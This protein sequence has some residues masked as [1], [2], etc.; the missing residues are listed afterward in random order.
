LPE[1]KGTGAT[2]VIDRSG[3]HKIRIRPC[4]CQEALPLDVQLLRMGLFPTSFIN[5]K[6]VVTFQALED[7]RLDNLE[8]KTALLRY[9]NKLWRKTSINAWPMLPVRSMCL[10]S[11][12]CNEYKNFNV[13]QCSPEPLPRVL[14]SH[15]NVAEYTEYH[16]LWVC[17]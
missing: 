8:C 16:P 12:R 13:C 10:S 9:W 5:F 6:T 17:S 2:L 7:Q 4:C 11:M 1:L 14:K 15:V 3:L